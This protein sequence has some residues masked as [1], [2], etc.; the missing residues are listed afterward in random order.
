MQTEAH[1]PDAGER[2]TRLSCPDCCGVLAVR[3]EGAHGHVLFVCRIGH[4]YSIRDVLAAKEERLEERLWAALQALQ[5]MADFL[6][7]L[8]EQ[9]ERQG[10]SS[11]VAT[12][13][14]RAHRAEAAAHRLRA[15]IEWDRTTEVPAEVVLLSGRTPP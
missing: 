15:V 12:F 7:E 5:E 9:A 8:A 2:L 10:L 6:G 13:G 11:L 4:R 14:D 3:V 1:D